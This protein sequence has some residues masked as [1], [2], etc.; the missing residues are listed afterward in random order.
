VH[1]T[2]GARRRPSAGSRRPP[3]DIDQAVSMHKSIESLIRDAEQS[4]RPL[5]QV[6]LDKESAET[7]VPPEQIRARP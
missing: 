1:A 6:V 3:K 2:G 7:G 5:P 4:G